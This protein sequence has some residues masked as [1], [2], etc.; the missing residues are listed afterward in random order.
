[1]DSKS[2]LAVLN[3]TFAKSILWLIQSHQSFDLSLTTLLL[4][5]Y[6]VRVAVLSFLNNEFSS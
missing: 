1:M 3:C 4:Q 2:V 6:G 5:S